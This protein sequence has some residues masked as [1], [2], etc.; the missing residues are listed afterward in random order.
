MQPGTVHEQLYSQCNGLNITQPKALPKGIFLICGNRAWNGIP[1]RPQGGPCYLGKLTLFHPDI[2]MLL[3]LTQQE[4]HRGKRDIHE[5]SCE[6][7]KSPTFWNDFKTIA[8]AIISPGAVA[9]SAM[10]LSKQLA[11]WT[12]DEINETSQVLEMLTQDVQSVN[13]AVLQDR[14]AID[15]L[16]LA[17]GHGCEEFE[18]MC[19]MNLSDH[20]ESIHKRIKHIQDKLHQLSEEDGWDLDKWLKG[21]GLGSWLR[22]LIK[23][24]AVI[25]GV[26]LGLTTLLPCILNCI[27][28]FIKK[29]I[30]GMCSANLAFQKENGG[31]VESVVQPWLDGKGHSHGR[32]NLLEMGCGN[33]LP[34]S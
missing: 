30:D 19:C 21:L 32:M 12:K 14:A 8:L 31:S 13:H 2:T 26:L 28:G 34:L 9:A 15:F 22:M 33:T 17:Q 11:C 10:K 6:N 29:T 25:L 24:V 3:N 23:Y 7:M 27:Q 16:L 1:A 18:G 4:H 20:A 5:L